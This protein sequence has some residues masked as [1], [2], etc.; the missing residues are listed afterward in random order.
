MGPTASTDAPTGIIW[1]PQNPLTLQLGSDGSHSIHWC[2]NWD[3]MGPRASADAPTGIKWV[4]E[5]PLMLQ[6]G[7]KNLNQSAV[8]HGHI[9]LSILCGGSFFFHSRQVE[10]YHSKQR[11]MTTPQ[12]ADWL[13][14]QVSALATSPRLHATSL[15]TLTSMKKRLDDGDVIKAT[16]LSDFMVHYD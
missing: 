15:A 2:S 8:S 16:S 1:I 12:L 9:T 6:S 13:A 4:P 3:Q 14:S 5:H 10:I 11:P 7:N